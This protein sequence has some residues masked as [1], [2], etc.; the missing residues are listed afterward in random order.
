MTP[1]R[2][3]HL[4]R[5]SVGDCLG[6]SGTRRT[7]TPL[8]LQPTVVLC[9]FGDYWVCGFSIDLNLI[10]GM[11]N[12]FPLHLIDIN[13]AEYTIDKLDQHMT[14]C[15]EIS[16]I[17]CAHLDGPFTFGGPKDTI[18]VNKIE[19]EYPKPLKNAQCGK[20][21]FP[22]ILVADASGKRFLLSARNERPPSPTPSSC[23]FEFVKPKP[24]MLPSQE[25]ATSRLGRVSLFLLDWRNNS[26]YYGSVP[27]PLSDIVR[28]DS[29]WCYPT[30]T[31][32][33][34]LIL[35]LAITM[36]ALP[37]MCFFWLSLDSIYILNPNESGGSLP[38]EYKLCPFSILLDNEKE[39]P[40]RASRIDIMMQGMARICLQL[41]T[42]LEDI[43]VPNLQKRVIAATMR[44]PALIAACG[45]LSCACKLT[46]QSTDSK[47]LYA[48]LEARL[49]S[50]KYHFSK[51]RGLNL[52][53][54]LFGAHGRVDTNST[55]ESAKA[56]ARHVATIPIFFLMRTVG[57]VHA[58]KMYELPHLPCLIQLLNCRDSPQM[59]IPATEAIL[60]MLNRASTETQGTSKIIGLLS[61]YIGFIIPKYGGKEASHH[62]SSIGDLDWILRLKIVERIL[63]ELE[64]D[65]HYTR[66]QQ[67][68]QKILDCGLDQTI[69]LLQSLHRQGTI[70]VSAN[71]L[72]PLYRVIVMASFQFF[73]IMARYMC[74]P[75]VAP[76]ACTILNASQGANATIH[77]AEAQKFLS[78]M[79]V[80]SDFWSWPSVTNHSLPEYENQQALNAR[81]LEVWQNLDSQVFLMHAL[82][83][84]H[85]HLSSKTH[86]AIVDKLH[87]MAQM[88]ASTFATDTSY[89]DIL[90][91]VLD[92]LTNLVWNGQGQS[93]V[94]SF[95]SPSKSHAMA[96][97]F[98]N[99][100]AFM[101]VPKTRQI[102]SDEHFKNQTKRCFFIHTRP[103]DGNV[104]SG[105][106][107]ECNK[108]AQKD[109]LAH[110]EILIRDD[111][112]RLGLEKSELDICVQEWQSHTNII[113]SS[114][115]ALE[116]HFDGTNPES[117]PC[118]INILNRPPSGTETIIKWYGEESASSYY[119]PITE[120]FDAPNHYSDA[121]LEIPADRV[122]LD[123]QQVPLA[124]FLAKK[125]SC[126][127]ITCTNATK[128]SSVFN[129]SFKPITLAS[130]NYICRTG[131][132][133]G[134]SLIGTTGV[135][136]VRVI[137]AGETNAI[138]VGIAF[139]LNGAQDVSQILPGHSASSLGLDL[140]TG[141]VYYVDTEGKCQKLPYTMPANTYS[142]VMI[143]IANR[144][145]Y[146]VVDGTYY[147]PLPSADST[148]EAHFM[149][150]Q[151]STVHGLVRIECGGVFVA[152]QCM[153]NVPGTHAEFA[154]L[155]PVAHHLKM[156][157]QS[158]QACPHQL[159]HSRPIETRLKMSSEMSPGGNIFECL[160][161][162]HQTKICKIKMAND[163][164]G[165]DGCACLK[166]VQDAMAQ[167]ELQTHP[168]EPNKM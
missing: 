64:K 15:N 112:A 94:A 116:L 70:V 65:G 35:K 61:E 168:A 91:Y 166:Y 130:K 59:R 30:D 145:V 111:M 74:E 124:T 63:F 66:L 47:K 45:E 38:L 33:I 68:Q 162:S 75:T 157:Y 29:P 154:S 135:F 104:Q 87:Q 43:T 58:P 12:F 49:V 13:T 28:M 142:R 129:R 50:Q 127:T 22:N 23:F 153:T 137:D 110:F 115:Q 26:G 134:C 146:F 5:A 78:M 88:Y 7:R 118:A 80:M 89:G 39:R 139:D 117:L 125:E 114:M 107:C 67:C 69:V 152:T 165:G 84:W 156:A 119:V 123:L 34:H 99:M 86:S 136:D 77:P 82:P 106:T 108:V 109:C 10:A 100:K 60:K 133:D 158:A 147:P 85:Q 105:D 93:E 97:L 1:S 76:M 71:T 31:Q 151:N 32:L 51:Q 17:V 41:A 98:C 121:C 9:F 42:R 3:R 150:P 160:S 83:C 37:K 120:G 143:G 138:T 27:V 21:H 167:I 159:A 55:P 92:W 24:L 140:K 11:S 79:M 19:G 90:D 2:G 149:I 103:T 53:A 144:L 14:Y 113:R 46:T 8:F 81:L 155:N 122:N 4:P 126:K 73:T 148:R 128:S 25:W 95:V 62:V 54:N 52:N 16:S 132:N 96:K 164:C 40:V 44:Y 48:S 36:D 163:T 102:P 6:K 141:I 131:S 101:I 18:T 72:V 56:D 20:R 161:P 57:T